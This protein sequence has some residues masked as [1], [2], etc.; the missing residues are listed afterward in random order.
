MNQK[1]LL[2]KK[3]KRE[4]FGVKMTCL[5]HAGYDSTEVSSAAVGS[6]YS[7]FSNYMTRTI[8]YE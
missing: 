8:K 6:F 2:L 4:I 5:G 3:K 1:F 7:L